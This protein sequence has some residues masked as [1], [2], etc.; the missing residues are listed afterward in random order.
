ML[1]G[2]AAL[3]VVISHYLGM[4]W[5][6]R[7]DVSSLTGLPVLLDQFAPPAI[8]HL[9]T[10][11]QPIHLGPLGVAIFFLISGLARFFTACAD[12]F[13]DTPHGEE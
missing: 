11:P 6:F 5:F 7:T 12:E 3:I 10:L 2:V 8:T 1:R 13:S 9:F 4:F